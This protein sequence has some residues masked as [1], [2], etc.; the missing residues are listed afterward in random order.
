MS[1]AASSGYI[2]GP[3][4]VGALV[5]FARATAQRQ[6][7]IARREAE[8]ARQTTS[9]LVDQDILIVADMITFI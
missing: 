6:T 1:G 2:G 7:L 3:A 9:F 5:P 8:T 4:S